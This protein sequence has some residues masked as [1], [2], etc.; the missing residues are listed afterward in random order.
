MKKAPKFIVLLITIV[1]CIF[2]FAACSG[3]SAY[4][5]AVRNGFVGTEAEWLASLRG[6]DGT[7]GTDGSSIIITEE[8]YNKWIEAGNVGTFE[9]YVANMIAANTQEDRYNEAALNQAMRSVVSIRCGYNGITQAGAGVIIDGDKAVGTAYIVT[10]YHVLYSSS[11]QRVANRINVYLYGNEIINGIQTGTDTYEQIY[12]GNA[13]SA[14]YI[15][16]SLL[17]DL[18]V[19]KITNST[20][21]KNSDSIILSQDQFCDSDTVGAGKSVAVIGNPMAM[22]LSITTGVLSVPSEYL[23]L[24]AGDQRTTTTM[25]AMRVDS[26]INSG[27]SGGGLFT[28]DGKLLGIVNAKNTQSTITNVGYAIPINV[29]MGIA[30]RIIDNKVM[31]DGNG[32]VTKCILGINPSILSTK[33]VYSNGTLRTVET[34]SVGALLSVNYPA[35]GVLQTGDIINTATLNGKTVTIEHTYQLSDLLYYGDQGDVLTLNITR[36]SQNLNAN[37]TLQSAVS[38]DS[39][40]SITKWPYFI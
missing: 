30:N 35:Y 32:I 13:I 26:A 36:G 34:V 1:V 19:I 33:G 15:G 29:A 22:G 3:Q 37:I 4:E 17:Y 28:G 9:D 39:F 12:S 27:N 11:S 14:T 20:I 31:Q 10:N 21:F 23:T 38:I 40:S 5:I 8:N 16:G 25:R 7:N 24:L 18:A 6:S 2:S